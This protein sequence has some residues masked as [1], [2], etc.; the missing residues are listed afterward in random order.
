MKEYSYDSSDG[1]DFRDYREFK[2]QFN[3]DW[4]THFNTNK[5]CVETSNHGWQNNSGSFD[6]TYSSGEDFL[7]EITEGISDASFDVEFRDGVVFVTLYS[8]D[9]PTGAIFNAYAE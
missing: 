1:G 4:D 5:F 3:R 2:E 6:K 8:H 7:Q 9:N